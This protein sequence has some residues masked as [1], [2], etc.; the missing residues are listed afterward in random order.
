VYVEAS[1]AATCEAIA[2]K[3]EDAVVEFC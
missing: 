2:K 1:D 3:V